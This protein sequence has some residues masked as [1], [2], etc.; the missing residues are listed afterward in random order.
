MG[1][2]SDGFNGKT[3]AMTISNFWAEV[4][5]VE[6]QRLVI[7]A[8]TSLHKQYIKHCFNRNILCK[9]GV[10]FCHFIGFSAPSTQWSHRIWKLARSVLYQQEGRVCTKHPQMIQPALQCYSHTEA[11]KSCCSL[12]TIGTWE[13]SVSCRPPV[14]SSTSSAPSKGEI[15]KLEVI[16][17]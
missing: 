9:H 11:P 13:V 12:F 2:P 1:N 3:I 4:T 14:R 10:R 16:Y 17:K 8:H 6:S 7:H 15:S 5:L